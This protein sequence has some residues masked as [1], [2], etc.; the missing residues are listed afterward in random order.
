MLCHDIYQSLSIDIF[1]SSGRPYYSLGRIH[2]SLI[3]S[4]DKYPQEPQSGKFLVVSGGDGYEDFRASGSTLS[5][6]DDSTNHLLLW[7]V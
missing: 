2:E 7:S 5:G 6:R 3:N 1:S 4:R